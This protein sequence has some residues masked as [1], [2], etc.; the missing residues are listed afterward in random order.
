M[1]IPF[2]SYTHDLSFQRRIDALELLE[3]K[4]LTANEMDRIERG[5]IKYDIMWWIN[6]VGFLCFGFILY[7]GQLLDRCTAHSLSLTRGLYSF[8]LGYQY[9]LLGDLLAGSLLWEEYKYV[10]YKYEPLIRANQIA[11]SPYFIHD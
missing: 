9:I 2:Y 4:E 5:L 8:F 3:L 11:K 10:F 6:R 1:L 7:K